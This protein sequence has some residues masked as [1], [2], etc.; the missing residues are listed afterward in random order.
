MEFV[1]L[2]FERAVFIS[3]ITIFETF[4]A[5]AIRTISVRNPQGEWQ[6]I[7]EAMNI[8]DIE[9]SRKFMPTIA[10]PQFKVN[11]IRIDT[12]GSASQNWVEIDAV[13][14]LGY[15]SLEAQQAVECQEIE[16]EAEPVVIKSVRPLITIHD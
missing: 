16:Q 6:A 4:H 15:P 7:Y 10:K 5:G 2:E 11:E 13:Q 9:R 12:D 1:E 8:E 14:L 3:G